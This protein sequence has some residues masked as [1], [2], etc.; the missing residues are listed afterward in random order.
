MEI[1]APVTPQHTDSL[2]I[3]TIHFQSSS[4]YFSVSSCVC[5]VVVVGGGGTDCVYAGTYMYVF[6]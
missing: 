3:Q 1:S 2:N 5:D 4:L 6:M